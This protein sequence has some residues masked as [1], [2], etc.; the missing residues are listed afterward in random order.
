MIAIQTI[1]R[2]EYIHSRSFIHRDIK[3]DNFLMGYRDPKTHVHIPYRE[4]KNLTGTAR[5]ASINT[6][7]GLEQSRR[8]DLESLGYVLMIS[9]RFVIYLNYCRSLKFEEKPDYDYLRSIF[10][11]L[12]RKKG[13]PDDYVF[14]WT[15]LTRNASS[16][17][18]ANA[19]AVHRE[20][21]N[22]DDSLAVA[23]DQQQ[24]ERI[25][26]HTERLESSGIGTAP[27][28]SSPLVKEEET[29]RRMLGEG[30]VDT[31]KDS[32]QNV[33]SNSPNAS[34]VLNAG[35]GGKDISLFSNS[36]NRR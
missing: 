28:L 19:T 3:P 14:D 10:Q 5:Y 7:L 6:H 18:R 33:V 15:A 36:R 8:D 29:S 30:G 20:T 34:H 4:G 23:L 27:I 13:F 31:L 24:E 35:I 17:L 11:A 32:K 21:K 2:I 22:R 1:T 9:R 16:S 26:D 25:L 12:Y